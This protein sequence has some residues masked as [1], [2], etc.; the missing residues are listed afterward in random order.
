MS[1]RIL[2]PNRGDEKEILELGMRNAD[3]LE[4]GINFI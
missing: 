2:D 4:D 3:F 1:V